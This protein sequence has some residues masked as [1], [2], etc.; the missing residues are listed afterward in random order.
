V[1]IPVIETARLRLRGHRHD[2]LPHC[3]AMWSDP[4]VTRFISA[5]ASTEQQTWARLLMYIGHWALMGYGYWVIEE[6]GSEDFVGEVGFADFKRNIVP[7]MKNA[8]ELGFALASRFHGKGYATESVR[9]AI[10]WADAHLPHRRTV[11]LINAQNAA[12]LGVVQ[13]CGYEVFEQSI[14]NEQPTLFL[15]RRVERGETRDNDVTS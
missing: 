2:D 4:N 5:R 9:A 7:S 8:P 13:K 1:S 3:V 10:C 12:S 6:K 11:C 14:Y 15:S